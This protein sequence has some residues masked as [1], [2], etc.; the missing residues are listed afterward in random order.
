MV[1]A[2]VS[3]RLVRLGI[4]VDQII[5]GHDYPES[6]SRTL[7][8][9][10]ALTAL[11]GTALK[12]EGK[13]I[14][15]TKTTGPITM[16]VADYHVPGHVRGYA[17]FDPAGI[18]S[19]T[20]NNT[21]PAQGQLL[22]SGHL[23]MTIDQGDEKSRYQ[24]I[25]A[26]EGQTLVD[27]AHTYFR[28]SEQLPTFIRLAVARHFAGGRWTWRAGGLMIQHVPFNAGQPDHETDGE[29]EQ[30]LLA[31]DDD[32]AWSRV[33]IL[34]ETVEDHELLDPTLS[35]ERLLYRLFHEENVTASDPT[36]VTARCRCSRE[37]IHTV[38]Q[39]FGGEE[40][41]D[42]REA[43]GNIAVTCEFCSTR[44]AFALDELN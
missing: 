2:S 29:R 9:A 28:Q 15:Q 16:V 8:E 4:S 22:G 39:S 20:A 25:V 7:G 35:P 43:D 10:I 19:K 17:A 32:A 34:A 40:L 6:V 18:A 44:Y 13:L 5:A 14:L 11:L 31:G 33:R 26:L 21:R 41:K 36:A 30:G 24:G 12:L 42:M 38:L 27:A 3:G 1:S 23:A 37:R